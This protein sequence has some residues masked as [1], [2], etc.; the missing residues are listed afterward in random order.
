MILQVN[1]FNHDQ[2]KN[3]SKCNEWILKNS[4]IIEVK[5]IQLRIGNSGEEF[6]LLFYFI[7]PEDVG[8]LE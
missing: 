2:G 5:D 1:R 3:F 8:K 7:K 6:A 4:G